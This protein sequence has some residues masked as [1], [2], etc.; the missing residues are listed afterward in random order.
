MAR[1]GN[2]STLKRRQ[3]HWGSHRSTAFYLDIGPIDVVL[4][5]PFLHWDSRLRLRAFRCRSFPLGFKT[6]LLGARVVS[7]LFFSYTLFG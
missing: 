3:S 6:R 2:F 5:A 7:F 4:T 1:Q